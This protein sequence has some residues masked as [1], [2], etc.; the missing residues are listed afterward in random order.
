[1]TEEQSLPLVQSPPAG[2]IVKAT[3]I[4]LA[5]A[6]VILF[7]V[8]LP[9]EYGIDPLRTGKALGLMG[10]SKAAETSN[11]TVGRAT[12][13]IAGIFTAQPGTYK[14]DSEDLAL[15]PGEGVEI[16]YH[17]RKGAE[18][19]YAWKATGKVQ[20]EFHGEPDQKPRPD[21]FESYELDNKV[22]RD[23]SFG[24]F[25]A[26][27]TGI[28]GWFWENKEKKEVQIHLTT[29]GFYDSAKMFAG[30]PKGEPLTVEDAK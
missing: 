1:M 27:T 2:A 24:S 15:G 13:V 4:A 14:V 20:F 17:M 28:H 29:A 7:T 9:A 11:G 19:L 18:M 23:H 12:P 16:K 3:L 6:L 8:V 30:D 21:Y 10:L 25:T 5:V 22:G 26:P